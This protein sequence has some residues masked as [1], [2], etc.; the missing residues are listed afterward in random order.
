LEVDILEV[1]I[2]E[3][4]ILEVDILEVNIETYHQLVTSPCLLSKMYVQIWAKSKFQN[5]VELLFSVAGIGFGCLSFG[6]R[7]IEPGK[8]YFVPK[9][10]QTP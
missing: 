10:D 1:D 3:V 4:N 6:L 9:L 2:L 7:K 8:Q 5:R